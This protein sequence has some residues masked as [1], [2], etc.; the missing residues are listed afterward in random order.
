V[1]L[2]VDQL[3]LDTNILVHWLRGQEAGAKLRSDYHLGSRRPRPILPLVVKAEVKSLALQFGWGGE[4]HEALDDLLR[5]LPIADISSEP[6]IT[7]YARL[8][9]ESRKVG[10]KM[11]KNDLWIAA[12]AAVQGAVILTTD[13]DFDHLHPTLVRIERVEVSTLLGNGS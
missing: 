9:Q 13:K 6:V 4:K 5:E 12:V 2:A 10:R 11:G 7:A 8:D 1:K 3:V